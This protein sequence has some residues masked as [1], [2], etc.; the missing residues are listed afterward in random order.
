MCV[1]TGRGAAGTTTRSVPRKLPSC[2]SRRRLRRCRNDLRLTMHLMRAVQR[3]LV[4]SLAASIVLPTPPALAASNSRLSELQARL[5]N[6]APRQR[7][8]G[9]PFASSGVRGQD[10]LR[11]PPWLEG[12]FR[13]TSNIVSAAAPL[14]RKYLPTD[15]ARLPIGDL[16]GRGAPLSY[17]VRFERRSSDGSIV[18]DREGN[19]RASQNA[20]AGYSRVETV[21]FDGSAG[22]KVQYSEFGKNNTYVGPSRAEVVRSQQFP[23]PHVLEGC[24]RW[25]GH[26]SRVPRLCS[27]STRAYKAA[28]TRR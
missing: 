1:F 24:A 21:V 23:N 25:S 19:L 12:D 10:S 13:V 11:F 28:R 26:H 17:V 3:R 15:L 20:A 9:G 2:G 7:D 22:L 4:L 6:D 5:T 14:G 18:S 16:R 8:G 27:T